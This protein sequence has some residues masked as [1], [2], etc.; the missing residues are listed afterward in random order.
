MHQL[1]GLTI[2]RD[3]K[4]PTQYCMSRHQSLYEALQRRQHPGQLEVIT[5]DIMVGGRVCLPLVVKQHPSLQSSQ[6]IGVLDRLWEALA[7]RRAEQ[8]KGLGLWGW[9]Q[10]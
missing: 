9:H 3:V 5:K 4:R 10:V 7:I 6:R 8:A 2:H 1:Q